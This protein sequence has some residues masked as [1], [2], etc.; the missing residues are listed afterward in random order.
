MEERKN[1]VRHLKHITKNRDYA[2]AFINE[3]IP[4]L[5]AYR[6][7]ATFLLYVDI[8]ELHITGAEFVEFLK[9]SAAGDCAG[10]TPIL[11]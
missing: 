8:Q 10:R 4:G 2:V 5:H 1:G 11:R 7:Q 6:P 3:H 9:G